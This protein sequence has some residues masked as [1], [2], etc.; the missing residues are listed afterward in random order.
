MNRFHWPHILRNALAFVL[1]AG[2]ATSAYAVKFTVTLKNG[3]TFETRYRPMQADFDPSY[4]LMMTDKGNWIALHNDEI[5]DIVSEAEASGFGYQLDTTT[6][7]VGWSP[8]DLVDDEGGEGGD[9]SVPR[10]EVTDGPVGAGNY[11][12][13]QFLSFSGAD[14]GGASTDI[15]LYVTPNDSTDD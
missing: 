8:N 13:N 3:T 4:S 2:L 9:E 11:S 7:Y 15:P 10:Y 14:P 6:L 5:A 12:I 1:L